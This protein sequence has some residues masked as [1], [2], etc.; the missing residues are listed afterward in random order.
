MPLKISKF[1]NIYTKVKWITLK[2]PKQKKQLV[3]K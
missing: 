3:D 2:Y 1:K